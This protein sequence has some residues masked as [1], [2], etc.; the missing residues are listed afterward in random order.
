MSIET[1]RHQYGTVFDHWQIGELLGA[2]KNGQTAVF[3]LRHKESSEEESAVKVITLIEEQ[4]KL[5]EFS[6]HRKAEYE[7]ELEKRKKHALKEVQFMYALKGYTNIVSYEDRVTEHWAENNSFGCDLLIRMELLC[8]LRK[9]IQTGRIFSEAEIIQIGKD[10]CTALILCHGEKEPIIHRDIKPENIFVNS[11]GTYKLGDFG[12]S[13]ILDKC[14]GATATT[15][16]G[17]PAYLA[18]EQTRKGYDERV[19]IYSLGLVLYELSNRNR[20][21]FAESSYDAE[22]AT[23]LRMAGNKLPTPRDASPDFAKV[24]LKA[25]AFKP[26]SRYRSAQEMREALEQI[27]IGNPVQHT[28]SRKN[29]DRSSNR[30][31]ETVSA[32][33][34]DEAGSSFETIPATHSSNS[35]SSFATI[36]ATSD[37]NKGSRANSPNQTS[38]DSTELLED[39]FADNHDETR[40]KAEAGDASAQNELGDNYF[41][42]RGVDIDY[43]QAVFWFQ[44]AASQGNAR[45]QFNLGYCY[46]YGKGVAKEISMAKALYQKAADQGSAEA[47]YHLGEIY[48]RGEGVEKAYVQ[49]F[50]LFQ[51]AAEQGVASALDRMGD[52]YYW[53]HGAE[54]SYSKAV[55]WY[56]KAVEKD[57]ASAMYSLGFCY[58]HG[59]GIEIDLKKAALLF[60]RAAQKGNSAAQKELNSIEPNESLYLADCLYY[61]QEIKEDR[62]KAISFFQKAADAGI[63]Y[64]E[65]SMGFCYGNG[66]GVTK[67]LN[68]AFEWYKKS[69]E[70]GNTAGMYRLGYSYLYGEGTPKDANAAV[71]WFEKAA[72]AGDVAS[73]RALGHCYETGTGVPKDIVKA[74]DYNLQ[75][76][77]QGNLEAAIQ[78]EQILT[79]ASRRDK[80]ILT[81]GGHTFANINKKHADEITKR[82]KKRREE[83]LEGFCGLATLVLAVVAIIA[84]VIMWFLNV[85]LWVNIVTVAVIGV[86]AA[87]FMTFAIYGIG[88]FDVSDWLAYSLIGGIGLPVVTA[89]LIAVIEAVLWIGKWIASF[90]A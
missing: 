26:N 59:Q 23:L 5:S 54:K 9:I 89:I 74:M 87:T 11:R 6:P 67:D 33:S 63:P 24:I 84:G 8:D 34:T 65:Y 70:H 31:F 56:R 22:K 45:G 3:H 90:F 16:I 60:F 53:G 44:K 43:A 12:V 32:D 28:K 62:V 14:H 41:F 19:D 58:K 49:A 82:K 55:E 76:M 66:H 10:I 40:A 61:G 88:L 57:H 21:P 46:E 30:A 39:L 83:K 78:Y 50:K 68:V 13:R 15:A 75:A 47:K 52:C 38:G 72:D 77:K 20:L 17:T 51:E 37:G 36:P 2:S 42:G 79:K 35:G 73:L 1:R 48:Y 29:T 69:A 86:I 85:P 25:C 4:G 27:T 64:A 81:S 18:P 80:Q 71:S 7:A